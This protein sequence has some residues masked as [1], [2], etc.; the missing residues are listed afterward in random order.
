MR[1]YIEG[2]K[3][4][5]IDV[6]VDRL[7]GFPDNIH[8]DGEGHYWIGIPTVSLLSNIITCCPTQNMYPH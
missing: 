8:Y 1:Y 6:F 7:L 4:G 5:T 2:E 3:E